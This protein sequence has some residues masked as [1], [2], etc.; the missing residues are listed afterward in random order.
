MYST[1]KGGGRAIGFERPGVFFYAN[2]FSYMYDYRSL[3]S[4]DLFEKTQLLNLEG[5]RHGFSWIRPADS[6]ESP[7]DL[8][9]LQL[10]AYSLSL[11]P[12]KIFNPIIKTKVIHARL[13]LIKSRQK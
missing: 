2:L 10:V 9:L 4:T 3:T 12:P 1:G 13:K 11:S 6:A 8:G 5:K 7:K